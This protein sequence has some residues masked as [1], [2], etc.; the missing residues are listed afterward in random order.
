[1]DDI[2]FSLAVIFALLL[3]SAFFSGSET[4]LTA[5]SRPYMHQLEAEGSRGARLVN[6]LIGARD[7]LIGAILLGNN[8]VNILASSLATSAMMTMFGEAGIAY[9]TAGMTVI[10][11]LFGEVLPKT[12]AIY[13]ANRVA[14]FVAPP[15]AAVVGL[16]SP[17]VRGIEV[18]TRVIFRLF[19]AKFATE[20]SIETAMMELRGAIEV[21]TSQDEVREERRMLRSILE[22]GDVEVGAV[23]THRR[24]TVTVDAGLP[25]DEAVDQILKT[26]YTRIPL[27][28]DQPDNIVGVIHAKDV[29]R[30]VRALGGEV[31]RLDLGELASPPWFIPDSTTLL[32]QLQAFRARREHFALVV[33]E[34]GALMGVVTLED[35]LEEI[36]GD[37]ADEH[38]VTVAGVHPQADGSYVVD[39]TVTIRDLNRQLEWRLP[40]DEAATVAGLVLHESR[41]IPNVGQVFRF[42]G[43]RFEILRRHRN[44]VTSLKV[45]PPAEPAREGG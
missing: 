37:I 12:Y 42:H 44:Q 13:H 34:Y 11:V 43:F 19:G 35:I 9:A 4:A 14:L 3:M 31:A 15:V 39:G 20:A 7:R 1:M 25:P 8:L 22:L 10:V 40:D 30:A 36:V 45:T 29:L 33:D 41:Q 28:R 32:E 18:V 26:P 21:H 2:A 17:V 23:M 6:R 24:K 38:D 16:L 5:V 27:W